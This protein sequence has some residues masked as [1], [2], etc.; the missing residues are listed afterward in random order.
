MNSVCCCQTINIQE[1]KT[2]NL[3]KKIKV[4]MFY[5]FQIFQK[6]NLKKIIQK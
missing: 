1:N 5:H 2:K 3:E 4:Q 6:L